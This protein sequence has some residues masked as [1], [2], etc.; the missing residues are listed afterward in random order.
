VPCGFVDGLHI[1]LQIVGPPAVDSMIL[2]MRG[3]TPMPSKPP[4]L[5]W[6]PKR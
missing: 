4:G 5:D 3:K 2:R 6:L 1:G